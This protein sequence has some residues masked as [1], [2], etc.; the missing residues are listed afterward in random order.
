MERF[1]GC[2][3]GGELGG[4]LSDGSVCGIQVWG[5]WRALGIGGGSKYQDFWVGWGGVFGFGLLWGSA[6]TEAFG[7]M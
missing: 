2:Q 1:W 7:E 4:L 5:G 6:A 3:V